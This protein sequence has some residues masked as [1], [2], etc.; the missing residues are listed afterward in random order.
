METTKKVILWDRLSIGN[1]EI[2]NEHKKLLEIYNDLV[3]LIE[4]RKSR[5]KFAEILSKM[6]DYSLIHFKKEERYMECLSYP[7][8][9]EHK[10]FH[11]NYIYRVAMYNIDL[12]GINPPNPEEIIKFLKEWWIYHILEIDVQY[13]DFK[14]ENALDVKY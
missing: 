12:L 14:K 9:K 5:E 13:E 8:I 3:D 1:P 10:D 6:T 4:F 11:R 2:D 7:K